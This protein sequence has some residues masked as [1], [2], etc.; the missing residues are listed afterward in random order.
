MSN[1]LHT[2]HAPATDKECWGKDNPQDINSWKNIHV[3]YAQ[4]GITLT[5]HSDC[6]IIPSKR[7]SRE[8]NFIYY[9]A[10]F[11]NSWICRERWTRHESLDITR[12]PSSLITFDGVKWKGGSTVQPAYYLLRAWSPGSSNWYMKKNTVPSFKRILSGTWWL[13]EPAHLERCSTQLACAEVA[14]KR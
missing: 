9:P 12:V 7:K 14:L 8:A 1:P 11:Q 6:I 3:I 5:N 4:L 10:L 13:W 2:I